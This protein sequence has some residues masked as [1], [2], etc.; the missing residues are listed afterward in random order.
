MVPAATAA[1]IGVCSHQRV[2]APGG[3]LSVLLTF[4]V[5]GEKVVEINVG[6]DHD[7]LRHADIS[8]LGEVP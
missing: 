4:T 7:K 2:V 8:V 3:R 1:A 5:R 6:A